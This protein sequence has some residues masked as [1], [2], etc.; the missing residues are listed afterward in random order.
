MADPLPLHLAGKM[1]TGGL[2]RKDQGV[3]EKTLREG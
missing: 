1:Q 3:G 2:R